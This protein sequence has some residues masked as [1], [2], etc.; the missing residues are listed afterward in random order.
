M[1]NIIMPRSGSPRNSTFAI[2][3]P[4]DKFFVPQNTV[5]ASSRHVNLTERDP[6][7]MVFD[8]IKIIDKPVK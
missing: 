7:R 8:I 5:A 1:G 4:A 6:Y 3:S 2:G